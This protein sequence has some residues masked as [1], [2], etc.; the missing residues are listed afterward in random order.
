MVL[1]L[2][3]L[4]DERE[5]FLLA[6]SSGCLSLAI[7]ISSTQKVHDEHQHGKNTKQSRLK[8]AVWMRPV[9]QGLCIIFFP[10]LTF[11]ASCQYIIIHPNYSASY[12]ALV[13]VLIVIFKRF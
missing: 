6:L 9:S 13:C 10:V 12:L 4:Y 11:E 2:E 3:I 7:S 8:V 5:N 1:Y